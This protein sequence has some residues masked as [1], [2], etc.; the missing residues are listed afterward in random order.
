M[1]IARNEN[2]TNSLTKAKTK[3]KQEK[4]KRQRKNLKLSEM[5]TKSS[6]LDHKWYNSR[7]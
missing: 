5:K 1:E 3:L 6:M 7:Q 2:I 4:G